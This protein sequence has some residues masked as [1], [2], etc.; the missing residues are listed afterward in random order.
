MPYAVCQVSLQCTYAVLQE[1]VGF[2]TFPTPLS[3]HQHEGEEHQ[4]SSDSHPENQSESS[5][6]WEEGW[7]P[8]VSIF[9][10]QGP[11]PSINSK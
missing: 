2:G 10:D 9:S 4:K 7:C 3:V 6:S 11:D 8:L 1:A 5:S